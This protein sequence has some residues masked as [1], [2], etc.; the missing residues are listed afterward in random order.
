[1]SLQNLSNE[2]YDVEL[3][4]IAFFR[5]FANCNYIELSKWELSTWGY[6][7]FA[8]IGAVILPYSLAYFIALLGF[9]SSGIVAGSY[10][11]WFMSLYGGAVKAGSICSILQSIGVVGLGSSGTTLLGSIGATTGAIFG[12]QLLKH[13]KDNK[14]TEANLAL[15]NEF[16]EIEKNDVINGISINIHQKLLTNKDFIDTF[17]QVFSLTIIF[18]SSKNYQFFI[19]NRDYEYFLGRYLLAMLIKGFDR[20]RIIVF[21]KEEKIGFNIDLSNFGFEPVV[22]NNI[23]EISAANYFQVLETS[24]ENYNELKGT[25]TTLWKIISGLDLSTFGLFNF[26]ESNTDEMDEMTENSDKVT[27]EGYYYYAADMFN[28][29]YKKLN[30][31]FKA[32]KSEL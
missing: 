21:Q 11:S 8:T 14:L 26:M 1:M 28:K 23:D 17:L 2:A 15:L 30:K 4:Q 3:F 20:S 31:K 27:D 32:F 22:E 25:G 5:E 16:L 6:A 13:I 18:A 24:I 12:E 29:G 9:G 7:V 19:N 10:A